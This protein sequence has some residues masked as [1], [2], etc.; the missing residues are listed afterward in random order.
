MSDRHNSGQHE[1]KIDRTVDN[2]RTEMWMRHEIDRRADDTRYM[3]RMVDNR[4]LRQ[5]RG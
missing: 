3:G 1:G 5:T 4:S 2:R